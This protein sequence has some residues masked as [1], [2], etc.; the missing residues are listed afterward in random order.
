M[1][2]CGG[3]KWCPGT[4]SIHR[5]KD[6]QSA[7]R[8]EIPTHQYLW[9]NRLVVHGPMAENGRK[10]L[11]DNEKNGEPGRTWTSDQWIMRLHH[12]DGNPTDY[13]GVSHLSTLPL[14]VSLPVGAW[15]V[16][17]SW[18]PVVTENQP[19]SNRNFGPNSYQYCSIQKRQGVEVEAEK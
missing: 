18:F 11:K 8:F 13:Q 4:K 9:T 5:H 12:R 14:P 16:P 17:E 2:D 15:F 3:K 7:Y 6:F 10:L 19:I 1:N